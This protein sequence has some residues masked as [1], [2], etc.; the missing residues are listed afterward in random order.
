MFWARLHVHLTCR[1]NH[2]VTMSCQ[3]RSCT[4]SVWSRQAH[5]ST[6]SPSVTR[7]ACPVSPGD[8]ETCSRYN[9]HNKCLLKRSW[10]LPNRE[11][12]SG[13]R[14]SALQWPWNF[15]FSGGGR[16]ARRW[17]QIS[18]RHISKT[19]KDNPITLSIWYSNLGE[20]RSLYR[21][22][23]DWKLCEVVWRR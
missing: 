5:T 23:V 22:K 7:S 14:I 13:L 4:N 18:N 21:L 2:S 19:A 3:C 10:R 20:T 12:T 17:G 11:W 9:A 15:P 1:Q 8:H 16:Y 6:S